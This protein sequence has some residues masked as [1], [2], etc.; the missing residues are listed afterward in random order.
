LLQSEADL[1]D[2]D[3]NTIVARATRMIDWIKA[4]KHRTPDDYDTFIKQVRDEK[5]SD[6]VEVQAKL[7]ALESWLAEYNYIKEAKAT[8]VG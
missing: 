7:A 8:E 5:I 1:E 2:E 4:N 6:S 3:E